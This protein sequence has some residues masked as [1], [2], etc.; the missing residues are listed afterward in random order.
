MN[1]RTLATLVFL[2][3]LGF[4]T[5]AQADPIRAVR[6]DYTLDPV[7]KRCP[8]E[9]VFRDTVN[10]RMRFDP[11][12]DKAPVQLVVT[13]HYREGRYDGRAELIGTGEP[14]ARDVPRVR[15]CRDLIHALGIKVALKLDPREPTPTSP[16]PKPPPAGPS[17]PPPRKAEKAVP[18]ARSFRIRAGVSGNLAM[19][20]APSDVA[21]EG[22]ADVGFKWSMFSLSGEFRGAPPAGSR[23]PVSSTPGTALTWQPSDAAGVST[24]RLVGAIVPCLHWP[25]S[26]SWLNPTPVVCAVGQAGGVFVEGS[27]LEGGRTVTYGA[28]GGRLAFELDLFKWFTKRLGTDFLLTGR[29]GADFLGVINRPV[30]HFQEQTLWTAPPFSMAF[31][32]GVVASL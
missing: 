31:G 8:S 16:E 5:A 17:S 12:A 4:S 30:V 32:G 9:Q 10:G 7:A 14:W 2:A 25:L 26:K 11:F 27:G 21:F 29:L 22:A 13:I 24:Y 20:I 15:D 3:V 18:A 28:A 6:L 23:F 19:W 1:T